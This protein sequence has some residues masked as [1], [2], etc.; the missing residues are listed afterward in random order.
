VPSSVLARTLVATLVL[1]PVTA[2]SS[3]LAVSPPNPPPTGAAAFDCSAIHGRLPDRVAG[4]T[5]TALTPKSPLTS[6]WGT[7]AIVM[8]CGVGAP[9]ALT[10]TAQLI[11]V[12]GVDWLPEQLTHGYLFTTVGR[13]VGVEVSVPDAYSPEADALADISPAISAIDPAAG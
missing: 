6:A 12:D 13:R 8:R 5:V 2:C 11:T 7:P 1:L 10:P 3:G 9:A 4:Q